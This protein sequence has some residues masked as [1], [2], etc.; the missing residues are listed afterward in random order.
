VDGARSIEL[1][2]S[3]DLCRTKDVTFRFEV[4]L[5][6][7]ISEGQLGI[8]FADTHGLVLFTQ[9]LPLEE[10]APGRITIV[11]TFPSLPL[12]EGSYNISCTISSGGSSLAIRETPE[13]TVLAGR[14]IA[15]SAAVRLRKM[16]GDVRL[17][18]LRSK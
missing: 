6:A 3:F 13:L 17:E 9:Y 8:S 2:S 16:A 18:G 12:S 15:P 7:T 5:A 11:L 1:V 10:R 4:E 14:N